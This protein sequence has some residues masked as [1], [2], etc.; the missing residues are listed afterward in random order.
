[1]DLM[2][3]G[4]VGPWF[5]SGC[6]YVM[7]YCDIYGTDLYKIGCTGRDPEVRLAEIKRNEGNYFIT[8]V[9]SIQ[10]NEIYSAETAAQ[11]AVKEIGMVKDP[12]RG[13]ATDWFVSRSFTPE[14]VFGVVVQAVMEHNALLDN[15]LGR[16]SHWNEW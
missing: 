13:G 10:A 4:A 16:R 11:K 3:G 7:H 5:G 2:Q 15:Y 9:G 14:Q 8:L 6:V 12:S 1:M